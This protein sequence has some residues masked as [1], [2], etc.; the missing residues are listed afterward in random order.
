MTNNGAVCAPRKVSGFT[1]SFPE[2]YRSVGHQKGE[3]K[4]KKV[5][6][7]IFQATFTGLGALERC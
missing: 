3:R 4:L 2:V 7:S 6:F 5:N 1:D